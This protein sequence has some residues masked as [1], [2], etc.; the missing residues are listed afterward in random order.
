MC[1]V[2]AVVLIPL[3][4]S[5]GWC[6]Q[7]GT[8]GSGAA[9]APTVRG[10]V[11]APPSSCKHSCRENIRAPAHVA[12][13]GALISWAA[14]PESGCLMPMGTSVS[15]VNVGGRQ[16][17]VSRSMDTLSVSPLMS[18]LFIF[19]QFLLKNYFEVYFLYH[20]IHPFQVY[21][22]VITSNFTKWSRHH[23]KAV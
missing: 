15:T 8:R 21:K 18:A 17:L 6:S 19:Q 5:R 7:Q 3:R 20:K 1:V 22:S 14:H 23:H 9:P 16:S 4:Q 13:K 2:L 10:G 11:R 12:D